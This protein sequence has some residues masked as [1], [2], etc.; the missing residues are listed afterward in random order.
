MDLDELQDKI[1]HYVKNE[2]NIRVLLVHPHEKNNI[3]AYSNVDDI[4]LT[5]M[6]AHSLVILLIRDIH[7]NYSYSRLRTLLMSK[8]TYVTL[9]YSPIALES[10]FEKVIHP[11]KIDAVCIGLLSFQ[12]QLGTYL[13]KLK[14]FDSYV[15]IFFDSFS[16]VFPGGLLLCKLIDMKKNIFKVVKSNQKIAQFAAFD[17][18]MSNHFSKFHIEKFVPYPDSYKLV[19]KFKEVISEEI[20]SFTLEHR[21]NDRYKNEPTW[22]RSKVSAIQ[23]NKGYFLYSIED[24]SEIREVSTFTKVRPVLTMRKSK[25]DLL[26]GLYTYKNFIYYS[27][28]MLINNCDTSFVMVALNVSSFSVIN[29]IFGHSSGNLLLQSIAKVLVDIYGPVGIYG[30]G[31]FDSFLLCVPQEKFFPEILAK[32]LKID[33]SEH[34]IMMKP[35]IN[36]G[37]YQIVDNTQEV[38]NMISNPHFALRRVKGNSEQTYAYF[39]KEMSN[40]IAEELIINSEKEIALSSGQFIPYFQPVLDLKTNSIAAAEV[41]IRWQHPKKGLLSP[42][43]FIPL[44]EENGFISKID[45]YMLSMAC[46]FLQEREAQGKSLIPLSIN[47]SRKSI[48]ARTLA[49]EQEAIVRSMGIPTKYIRF[50]ITETAY[51]GDTTIVAEMVNDLRKRGFEVLMDDFGSGYSSLNMLNDIKVDYLKM[52][53]KFLGNFDRSE[54]SRSIVSFVINMA[55]YLD[56]EVIAEGVETIDQFDY[57]KTACCDNIQGYYYAKPMPAEQFTRFVDE[58][59]L[60]IEK[61]KKTLSGF[62]EERIGNISIIMDSFAKETQ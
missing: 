28:K 20:T 9:L 56:L 38:E 21:L 62:D 53:M 2:D 32:H 58:N 26:T 51:A 24:I 45:L 61:H 7:D 19:C 22:V 44:F 36:F 14:Q 31:E 11:L 4:P 57:L 60:M 49:Q 29:E 12:Q 43:K 50:E 25:F 13:T 18:D 15:S 10:S 37:I 3:L 47:L 46:K 23:H 41:L 59:T 17:G 54:R 35:L 55:K 5:S 1:L 33:L 40:K 16:N 27:H 52:D 39:D 8:R 34:G 30:R 6:N 42:F 48:N